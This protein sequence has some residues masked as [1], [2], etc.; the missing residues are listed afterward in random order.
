[1]KKL[2]K[3]KTGIV[4]RNLAFAKIASKIG[5]D[6]YLSKKD[7]LQEKLSD[8]LI[9]RAALLKGELGEL[10]G[11]FLKAGQMLSMYAGDM[12]PKEFSSVLIELQSKTSYLD[13][14]IIKL[15]LNQHILD[16]LKIR[17]KA[18]AAASIGQVHLASDINNNEYA[19]K[20]QYKNIGKLIDTDLWMLKKILDLLKIFPKSYDFSDTFK[21]I[22]QML[23]LEMDYEHEF[24]CASLFYKNVGNEY[25]VPKVYKEYSTK[26]A[27]CM[28]YIKADSVESFLEVASIENKQKLAYS[29]FNLFLKEIFVW[30]LLQSDAHPGNYFIENNKWVLI[31]FGACK[32]IENTLYEDLIEALF[33]QN[34]TLMFNALDRQGSM[35]LEKTD[36]DFFWDYC[37]LI[38]TPLQDCDYNWADSDIVNQ[39][40]DKVKTLQTKVKFHRLPS[41]NIFIDRKIGGLYFM[42]KKFAV[43]LNLHQFYSDFKKSL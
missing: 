13:F 14:D 26:N 30:K 19:L 2:K 21:E 10:K 15:Q 9:K 18:I 25:I 39:V 38:S 5:K 37:L 42:L 28:E 22:K 40:M 16:E 32:E 20:I 35:D 23:L 29:F 8:T 41:E 27:I 11:S 43:T 1:M 12:L 31:D 6:L 33:T 24:K 36:F 34:K 17:P 3:L 7:L 4:A